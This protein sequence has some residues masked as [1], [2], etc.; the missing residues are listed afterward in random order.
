MNN[1]SD[2]F[3]LFEQRSARSRFLFPCGLAS[4]DSFFSPDRQTT[5]LSVSFHLR[6]RLH[7]ES[8]PLSEFWTSP[9]THTRFAAQQ[10]RTRSALTAAAPTLDDIGYH[11]IQQPLQVFRIQQ[12]CWVKY[13]QSGKLGLGLELGSAYPLP[14]LLSSRYLISRE[15]GP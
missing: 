11:N 14:V 7:V 12:T 8:S 9:R 4:V 3:C 13:T 1:S 15:G 5:T 6:V 2:V 10:L